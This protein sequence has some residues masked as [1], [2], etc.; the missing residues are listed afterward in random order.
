[1]DYKY[2]KVHEPAMKLPLKVFERAP[3]KGGVITL[4]IQAQNENEMSI[5]ISGSATWAYRQQFTQ[6]GVGGGWERPDSEGQG[7]F[8]RTLT[9]L[10]VMK[11][12]DKEKLFHVLGGGVLNDLAVQV[13][14]EG[15]DEEDSAVF[16]CI[17]EL[18]SLSKMHFE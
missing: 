15:D 11:T 3:V 7:L 9:N 5:V 17:E 16:G 13:F 8:L 1:M 18:T 6:A 2:Y 10:D 4:N 12:E 14:I